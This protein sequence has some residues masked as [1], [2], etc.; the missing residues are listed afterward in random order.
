[1]YFH[2]GRANNFICMCY[3]KN[4][5][6]L[7][8]FA[9]SKKVPNKLIVFGN[10]FHPYTMREFSD[11]IAKHFGIKIRTIPYILAF[12]GAFSLGVLKLFGFKVPLYPFRLK[13]IMTSYC[14]DISNVVNLG[15]F[16]LRSFNWR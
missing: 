15:F 8:L 10:D 12:L 7:S 9:T 13:N 4:L 6:G 11:E 16:N 1:M 2:I 5:I 3:V 14:Y